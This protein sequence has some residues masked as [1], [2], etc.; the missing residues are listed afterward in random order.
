MTDALRVILVD[1]SDH[2]AREIVRALEHD[3]FALD[4]ERVD[5]RQAIRSALS[6]SEW[7]LMISDNSLTGPS[8]EDA[9]RL[10]R[11]SGIDIPFIVVSDTIGEEAAVALMKAGAHDLVLKGNL[12]R[13]AAVI[14]RELQQARTRRQG[15]RAE[16]EA[17]LLALALRNVSQCVSITDTSGRMIFI[18]EAFATTLGYSAE[19]LL[20]QNIS[21]VR[22]P[23]NPSELSGTM[24]A[25]TLEGGWTGEVLYR[26]RDGQDLTF[27]L[28]TR[29]LRDEHDHVVALIAVGTDITERKAAQSRLRLLSEAIEASP[30]GVSVI[31]RSGRIISVNP[32]FEW[33]TGQ[34]GPATVGK[35]L[36][37]VLGVMG[38]GASCSLAEA[39]RHEVPWNGEISGSRSDGRRFI[40]RITVTPVVD[41]AG[42]TRHMM[43]VLED[44]T[45]RAGAVAALRESEER[46][47]DFV[48]HSLV[49]FYRSTPGGELVMA[50]A[51]LLSMLGASSVDQLNAD[52]LPRW[53]ARAGYPRHDFERRI[54]SEGHVSGFETSWSRPDG[55]HVYARENARAVRAPSGE[56]V[57][58]EGTMEDLTTQRAL[59]SQIVRAQRMEAIG[60][61]AG[62]VAHDFNNLLQAM[63]SLVE[64]ARQPASSRHDL[65]ANLIELAD[66]IRRGAGLT[67]QLLLF[68]RQDLSKPERLELNEVIRSATRMLKRVTRENIEFQLELLDQPLS[69]EADRGQVEQVLLNLVINAADAMPEGGRLAIQTGCRAA[70]SVWFSVADTGCGIPAAIRDKVCE[71]FFTTKPSG[72]GTGLGLAVVRDIVERFGGRI[73]FESEEGR[74]TEVVVDLPRAGSGAV[75][76]LAPAP[77][78][79]TGPAEP[80]TVPVLIVEDEMAARIGL[81][82]VLRLLG[83]EVAS[84]GDAATAR[85]LAG[86]TAFSVFLV[87][88]VLPDGSGIDLAEEL[89]GGRTDTTVILMSGYAEDARIR[90]AVAEG[91]VRYLQKP[92]GMSDLARELQ[93]A[94]AA[95]RSAD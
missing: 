63:L 83:Y 90:H 70:G 74:G 82:R 9:L 60:Q 75:P 32:A 51:A 52:G 91:R 43:V 47:R 93:A 42:T 40:A 8:A 12:T 33:L 29:P 19:E 46:F 14:E 80:A 55:T 13:L 88:L 17:T 4:W 67:R 92:F 86:R 5:S 37:E 77:D 45:E 58:Y 84:A 59:E 94:L 28:S 3:G 39:L 73:R 57:Y 72:R 35:H 18:N 89:S 1:G 27:E 44:D 49:G 41:D 6:F 48:K 81:E 76:A 30:A 10:L 36:T 79:A 23:D 38:G 20:G 69:L 34:S 62:G 78:A 64:G 7:D 21:L 65:D 68:A 24:R 50:N 54:A 56:I 16:A 22:S 2:D 95:P 11:E 26:R 85:E 25:A 66:L 15:R 61:L 31:D 53:S 87:D 71:P